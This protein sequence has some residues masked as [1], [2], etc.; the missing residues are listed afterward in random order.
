MLPFF[1]A[2]KSHFDSFLF[3]KDF[4]TG[5]W[6]TKEVDRETQGLE[7]ERIYNR[8]QQAT[9]EMEP[10]AGMALIRLPS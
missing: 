9:W 2:I 10:A 5:M 6:N 8:N 4:R 7:G 1:E 3:A